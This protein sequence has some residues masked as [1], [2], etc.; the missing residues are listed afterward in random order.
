MKEKLS[1]T[2]EMGIPKEEEG[3][4][5]RVSRTSHPNKFGQ[6]LGCKL[7]DEDG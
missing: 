7:C 6:L 3:T 1:D 4:V 2:T 5:I